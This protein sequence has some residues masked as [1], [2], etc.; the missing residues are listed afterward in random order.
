MLRG[1]QQ[2]LTKG[3]AYLERGCRRDSAQACTDLGFTLEHRDRDRA[4]RAFQDACTLDPTLCSNLAG[5]AVRERLT[6]PSVTDVRALGLAA[7]EKACPATRPD[8]VA[9]GSAAEFHLCGWGGARDLAK[10]LTFAQRGCDDGRPGPCDLV[11]DVHA[12]N[13]STEKQREAL[14]RGCRLGGTASCSKLGVLVEDP[15]RALALHEL[16]CSRGNAD[17]CARLAELLARDGAN[18]A[19]ARELAAASCAKFSLMGCRLAAK[20]ATDDGERARYDAQSALL[21]EGYCR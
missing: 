21:H 7:A 15:A 9:C 6:T 3:L 19:R 14:E 10:A 1:V 4:L 17:G 5:F 2:D 20:W 12:E 18:E 8:A 11:A 16:S 13:K